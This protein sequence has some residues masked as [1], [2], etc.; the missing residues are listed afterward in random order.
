MSTAS[1]SP[2]FNEKSFRL[3]NSF[4]ARLRERVLNKLED[5]ML[6]QSSDEIT[7]EDVRWA[8][9]AAVAEFME[10]FSSPAAPR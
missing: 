4:D 8:I 1:R 2:K 5:R 9:N 6:D 10:K 3:L 7:E